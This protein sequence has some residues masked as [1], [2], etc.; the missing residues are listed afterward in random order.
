[1]SADAGEVARARL[2]WP[3]TPTAT[4]PALR[5]EL[6]LL[7]V[8]DQGGSLWLRSSEK[9]RDGV[10]SLWRRGVIH[11]WGTLRFTSATI[12][13]TIAMAIRSFAVSSAASSP[14]RRLARCRA[15]RMPSPAAAALTTAGI[16]PS[17]RAGAKSAACCSGVSTAVSADTVTVLLPA[18]FSGGAVPL[19]VR[20]RRRRP[21][22]FTSF[23]VPASSSLSS[24]P[25]TPSVRPAGI[26]RYNSRHRAAGGWRYLL[27]LGDARK[28]PT[29]GVSD[30]VNTTDNAPEA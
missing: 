5:L 29:S 13:G 3:A 9:L 4:C 30:T 24:M 12:F 7:A 2:A 19:G 27:L 20:A 26:R 1:L 11:P 17:T 8:G 28:P 23:Q 22:S 25:L 21:S 14:A 6:H 10:A 16:V 15:A 18:V